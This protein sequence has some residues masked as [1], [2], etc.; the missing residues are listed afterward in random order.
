VLPH[1]EGH[2]TQEKSQARGVTLEALRRW[3]LDVAWPYFSGAREVLELGAGNGFQASIIASRG[4]RVVALDIAPR[5]PT[6][7]PVEVYDGRKIPYATGSFDLV[8]TSHCLEHIDRLVPFL[9]EMK[10]V[11]RTGGKAIHVL[12]TS[13]WRLWTSLAHYG[14]AARRACGLPS[15]GW[16]GQG[17]SPTHGSLWGRGLGFWLTRV[18]VAGPHGAYP[19]ALHELWYYSEKCCKRTFQ[20]VGFQ[21][22]ATQLSGLFYTG[23]ALCPW[24]GL[25]ARR[26]LAGYLGS[27]SRIYV[28]RRP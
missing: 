18:L 19:S 6:Y 13:S 15:P 8:F 21:L 26:R 5:S 11:L 1:R 24:L 10:R 3:E 23:Y 14:Y 27:S 28:L 4:L 25:E 9:S 17:P 2:S 12:P 7:Y 20:A 16:G 22:E